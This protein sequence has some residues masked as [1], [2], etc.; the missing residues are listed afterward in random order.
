MHKNFV[1]SIPQ[2]VLLH[3]ERVKEIAEGLP[4]CVV[5]HEK[6]GDMLYYSSITARNDFCIALIRQNINPYSE[7]L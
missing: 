4:G 7:N 2:P 6:S 5:K 1:S 3:N